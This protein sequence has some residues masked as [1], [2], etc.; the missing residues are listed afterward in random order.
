MSYC[1]AY[2]DIAVLPEKCVR[3][4]YKFAQILSMIARI[5]NL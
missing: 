5:I 1:L 4:Q 2:A 3:E